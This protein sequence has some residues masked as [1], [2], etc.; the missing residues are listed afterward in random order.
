MAAI[1]KMATER[2]FK[3]VEQNPRAFNFGFEMH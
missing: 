2:K 3:K 1:F